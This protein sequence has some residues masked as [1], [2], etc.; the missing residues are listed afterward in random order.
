MDIKGPPSINKVAEVTG[1]GVH[2]GD[3]RVKDT[4]VDQVK[5]SV[6]HAVNITIEKVVNRWAEEFV[7]EVKR[8]ARKRDQQSYERP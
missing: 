3:R 4:S 7:V 6:K 2:S 1:V 8:V 5:R